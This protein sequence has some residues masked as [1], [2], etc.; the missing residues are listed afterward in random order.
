MA[1]ERELGQD[2]FQQVGQFPGIR[3]GTQPSTESRWVVRATWVRGWSRWGGG[4]TLRLTG[5]VGE[6]WHVGA[7]SDTMPVCSDP[8]PALLTA[9]GR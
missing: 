2:V 8:G 1:A 5:E 9:T 7:A 3:A 4:G 6:P